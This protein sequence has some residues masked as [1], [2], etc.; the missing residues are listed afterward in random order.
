[1][2][3]LTILGKAARNSA[4]QACVRVKCSCGSPEFVCRKDSYDQGRTTSCG[5]TRRRKAPT[6]QPALKQPAPPAAAPALTPEWYAGQI[7]VKEAAADAA[8][9]R[10]AALEEKLA[11]ETFTNLDTHKQ[12][13]TEATT[14]RDLRA[15]IARLQIAKAKSETAVVKEQKSAADLVKDRIRALKGDQ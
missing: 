5:C 3:K 11:V 1:M 10:A 4:G 8:E 13:K 15:E 2:Q 12:R 7:A 14:A 6:P 9:S